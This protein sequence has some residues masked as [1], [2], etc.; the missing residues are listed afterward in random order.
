[1]VVIALAASKEEEGGFMSYVKTPRGIDRWIST[2]EIGRPLKLK[3]YVPR[4]F[5]VFLGPVF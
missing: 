2:S 3:T 4:L 5:S 1:M